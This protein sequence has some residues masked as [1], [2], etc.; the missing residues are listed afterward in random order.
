[1][2]ILINKPQ[3][4]SEKGI[5]K[6]ISIGGEGSKFI[7]TWSLK[8]DDGNWTDTLYD[9]IYMANSNKYKSKLLGY[10]YN[11]F[12]YKGIRVDAEPSFTGDN[13]DISCL[14]EDQVVYVS[15]FRHDFIATPKGLYLDGGRDYTR[16]NAA[17]NQFYKIFFDIKIGKYIMY[18]TLAHGHS[19]LDIEYTNYYEE[20]K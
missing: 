1:M 15:R 20:N 8:A 19:I 12:A 6:L 5:E 4:L 3:Y 16:S 13:K 7:G 2:K 9:V 17:P 14:M 18:S 10:T 11:P